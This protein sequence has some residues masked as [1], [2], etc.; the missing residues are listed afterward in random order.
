VSD[1][2][3]LDPKKSGDDPHDQIPQSVYSGWNDGEDKKQ[4]HRLRPSPMVVGIALRGRGRGGIIT[5]AV[6]ILIGL[7]F[8]LDHLGIIAYLYARI[9]WSCIPPPVRWNMPRAFRRVC[10]RET[11]TRR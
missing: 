1:E 10:T 7:A 5:G 8:L 11:S 9:F 6:L 3:N 4:G 2:K